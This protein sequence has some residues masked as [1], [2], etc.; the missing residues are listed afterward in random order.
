MAET[1]SGSWLGYKAA[2]RSQHPTGA[3]SKS[4][5]SHERCEVPGGHFTPGARISRALT[6]LMG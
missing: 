1:G 4:G 2:A 6:G 3:E 5:E